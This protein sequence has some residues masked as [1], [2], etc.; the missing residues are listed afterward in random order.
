MS[1]PGTGKYLFL[2]PRHDILRDT[3]EKILQDVARGILVPPVWKSF[4][5]FWSMGETAVDLWDCQPEMP[6][7][8][9]AKPS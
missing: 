3:I 5:H 4:P 9:G 2:H 8:T 7:Y 6:M 1:Q